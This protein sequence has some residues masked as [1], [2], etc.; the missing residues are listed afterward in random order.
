MLFIENLYSPQIKFLQRI[1]KESKK[2][3]VLQRA[4]CILLSY[5][6]FSVTELAR[7]FDK[8]KRTIYVWLNQWESQHFAGLYDEKGRGRKPKLNDN[9]RQQ[10]KKW[11]KEFP[12]NLKKVVALVRETYGVSVSKRTIKRILRNFN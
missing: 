5:K 6:G 4:H 9:Q 1:C 10:I 3:H 7:I 12:K 11:A 2:H 8:T